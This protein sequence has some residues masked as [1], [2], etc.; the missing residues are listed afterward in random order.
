MTGLLLAI[1]L[2]LLILAAAQIMRIYELSLK[3]SNKKE[4]IVT[5]RNN[6]NQ[7][8]LMLLF[9]ISLLVSFVWMVN[10][11]SPLFLPKPS[12]AHGL[13][14]DMLW[15]ISMGLIVV[16][17]FIVQPILF[18][19]A[20]K[21]RG[22]EGQKATYYEH[23]NKLEFIWTIVPAVVLAVLIVYGMTTWSN[24]WNP[25]NEE[26]P[27]IV[28]VYAQQ[29]KWTVRY[30]GTDNTLGN[31]NVRLIKGVNV[32][33]VDTLDPASQDDIITSELHLPLGKPIKFVFRAQDVIHSAYMPHF[34]AQ[35]N[36]VPGAQTS[37]KFTPTITTEEIRMDPDVIA[38]VGRINKIRREAGKDLYEYDY[39]LLCNKVCGSAHY[40]MQMPLIVETEAEYAQWL[41]EQKTVKESI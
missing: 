17:F 10:A 15:D 13:E 28:E 9:G 41:S 37:F 30:S 22:K 14:I 25:D 8:R 21:Y 7:G 16:T 4:Y 35:M 3:A 34:R 40:N 32:I 2:F 12:S 24:V 27:L 39:L 19:F 18:F 31:A 5:H 38:K 1:V 29:F 6:S 26:E 36:C 23:N 20:Y 33:G 11:W